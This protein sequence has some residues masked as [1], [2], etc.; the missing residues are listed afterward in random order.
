VVVYKIDRLTRSLA[1]FERHEVP[2]ASVTQ[3]FNNTTSMGRLMLNVLLSFAQ[4]KS[5]VTGERIR[6]K[7]AA[8]KRQGMWMGAPRLWATTSR[9]AC[10]SSTKPRRRWCAVSS[11]KC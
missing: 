2:F 10:W 5:E 6:N 3:Q 4:F 8:S 7:I 11:R 9:T 1:D